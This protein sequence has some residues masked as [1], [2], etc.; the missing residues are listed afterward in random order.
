[1]EVG[2]AVGR[3]VLQVPMDLFVDWLSPS[4]W[5]EGDFGISSFRNIPP[6][7]QHLSV[8]L[9]FNKVDIFWKLSSTL[10]PFSV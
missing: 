7:L 1:M 6:H 9:D 3:S 2:K 4:I 10:F 8:F 5:C